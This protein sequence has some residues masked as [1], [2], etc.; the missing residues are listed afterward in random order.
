[1][2]HELKSSQTI[3]QSELDYA[4]PDLLDDLFWNFIQDYLPELVARLYNERGIETTSYAVLSCLCNYVP[5]GNKVRL[6]CSLIYTLT[7]V[8]PISESPFPAVA[9]KIIYAAIAAIVLIVA[10]A[11][12]APHVADFLK[13]LF[14]KTTVI[15]TH[16]NNP[17]SPTYCTTTEE[18]ITEPDPLA[19]GGGFIFLLIALVIV[20]L[21]LG[22]RGRGKD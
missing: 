14:T 21:F 2:E 12:I 3:A 16:D 20:M 22:F 15:K 8:Q 17:E 13:S 4:A 5:E 7:T 19:L 18:T 1:M 6:H 10:T 11:I 9:L